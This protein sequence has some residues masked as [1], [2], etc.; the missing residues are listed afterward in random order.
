MTAAMASVKK[1]IP[2]GL[3]FKVLEGV[4]SGRIDAV[5][6]NP[7]LKVTNRWDLSDCFY[8]T[9]KK[10]DAM[11]FDVSRLSE[12]RTD[13]N[14]HVKE[15]CDKF[16]W[17][18]EKGQVHRGI[19]RHDIG[20]FPADRAV[21]AFQGRLYSISFENYRGLASLGVDIVLVEKEGTVDKMVPFTSDFGIAFVQSAGFIPEYGHM[22]AQAAAMAGANVC[23]LTDFDA[24]G[25]E[26]GYKVEGVTRIGTSLHMIDELNAQEDE[27]GNLF[28]QLDALNLMEGYN[29]STHWTSLK[30]LSEGRAKP[31]GSKKFHDVPMTLHNYEYI[32]L[33]NTK[34]EFS[35]GTEQTYIEFLEDKRIELNTFLDEVGAQRFWNWL[36][37]KLIETFPTRDYNRAVD[38]PA[39]VLT[40]TMQDFNVTLEAYLAATCLDTVDQF[41]DDLSEVGLD[42]DFIDTGAILGCIKEDLK[43]YLLADVEI[44]KI[45]SMLQKIIDFIQRK[46]RG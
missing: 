3:A 22:L 9:R 16:T 46:P 44:K 43:D 27:D 41:K 30:Y 36:R 15:W 38:V 11:G 7:D 35:D 26:L 6:D 34:Y 45:D 25:F 18:D 8:N 17:K 31:Q 1:P 29:G 39:S 13:L 2:K 40:E 42:D 20:I 12:K 5:I 28:E 33:L 32:H 10:L 21:M 14:E 4:L 37:G 24:S 19:K 23:I